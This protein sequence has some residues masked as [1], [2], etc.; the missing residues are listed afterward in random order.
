MDLYNLGGVSWWESQALYH[1][2]A[3]LGRE[4]LIIC[5]PTSPYVCLGLH[6]DLQ[7]EIDQEY[8]RLRGIPLLRRETGG[9]VV[10]L[11]SNQV[12]FQ[13]VLHKDNPL[14]P[15][16]R[17]RFYKKFLK[18]AIRL[19]RHFGVPAELKAP[20]D[21]V[22]DG[23][24]CSGNAAG[25]IGQCVA[26]VGNILIDF[27][28]RTMSRVL[29]VPGSTFRR[30]L[31]IAMREYMTVLADWLDDLPGYAGLAA[32]LIEEFARE[33]GR[34]SPR[35]PDTELLERA[36]R[37]GARLASSDWLFLPGRKLPY[38]KVKIAEGVYLIERPYGGDERLLAVVRDGKIADLE[39]I[40]RNE[41]NK[42]LW[43]A[44]IGCEWR[45]DLL[46]EFPVNI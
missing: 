1:A 20:A 5:Y 24:K 39:V 14:L 26:Y 9:G 43:E 45:E 10:Y 18:P 25:D 42:G 29:R 15:L 16:R 34:L 32:A 28:F 40:G 4:G 21:I 27:D 31:Q 13:L 33:F 44:Y 38:R 6:D 12:F 7:Q 46:A 19:Y 37:I 36:S 2:L 23:R 35:L 17:D 8:C 30:R 3:Y 11:D 22:A 41:L